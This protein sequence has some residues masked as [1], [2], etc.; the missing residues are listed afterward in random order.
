MEGSYCPTLYL[1]LI[2]FAIFIYKKILSNEDNMMFNKL[3][4]NRIKTN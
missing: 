2:D 4:I 3:Q 1:D